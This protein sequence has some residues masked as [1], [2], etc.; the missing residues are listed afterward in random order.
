MQGFGCLAFLALLGEEE[1][2]GG[3]DEDGGGDAAVE[4]EAFAAGVGVGGLDFVLQVAG[5]L[6]AGFEGLAFE[7]LELGDSVGDGD[8]LAFVFLAVAD[9]GDGEAY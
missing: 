7:G 4:W 8:G 3:E 9:V 6:V 2:A 1:G 5:D